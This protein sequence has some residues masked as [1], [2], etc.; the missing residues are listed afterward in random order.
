MESQ[1]SYLVEITPE[2]EY[3]YLELGEYLY[4]H[5]APSAADKKLT[6]ILDLAISLENRPNRGRVE[7]KL[8]LLGKD[9]RFL[10]YSYTSRKSIKVIYFVEESI[11]KV[12]V[13]DFF[14]TEMNDDKILKRTGL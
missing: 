1:Q 12:Y 7:E 4:Q 13:T 5:H 10:V 3:H 6:E 2:A 14:P 11:K 8:S 9:H